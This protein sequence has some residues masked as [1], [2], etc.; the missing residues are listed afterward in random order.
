MS[1][2]LRQLAPAAPQRPEPNPDLQSLLGPAPLLEGEDAA[3]YEALKAQ[4]RTAVAPKDAIEEIWVRDVVDLLWETLRLRRLKIK[5]MRSAKCDGLMR[6]LR[7]LK[8]N[9]TFEFV[10]DWGEGDLKTAAIVK[11]ALA[12]AGLGPDAIVAHT[13]VA[14]LDDIE[15]I[16]RMVMQSEARRNAVLR[17]IDRHREVLARRL[18]EISEKIED[19]ECEEVGATARLPEP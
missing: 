15:R 16:D 5:L 10:R 19:A 18:R 2:Q 12:D 17:E 4:I 7:S 8:Q 11:S 14:N 3:A 13:L 1:S 6:L 9:V